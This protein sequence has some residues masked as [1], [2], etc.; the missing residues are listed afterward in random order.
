MSELDL[1]AIRERERRATPGPW[2]WQTVHPYMDGSV[3]GRIAPRG[4]PAIVADRMQFADMVFLA[5]A[6]SDIPALLAALEK[7]TAELEK[8]HRL[9]A[10][11]GE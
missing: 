2:D 7:V 11:Y 4:K 5:S 10:G 8:M 1:D 9:D 3:Q 6:R